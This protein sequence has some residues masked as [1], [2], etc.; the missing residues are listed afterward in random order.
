MSMTWY[1]KYRHLI[2]ENNEVCVLIAVNETKQTGLAISISI[3]KYTI[4]AQ[5]L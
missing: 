3:D 5:Y 1:F 4:M 2:E